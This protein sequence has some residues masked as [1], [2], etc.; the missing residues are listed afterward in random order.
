MV[1]MVV[2]AVMVDCA[3]LLL[4]LLVL[5]G[6][7]KRRV[8]FAWQV[9]S[10]KLCLQQCLPEKRVPLLF[11]LF[12]TAAAKLF[13]PPP[14]RTVTSVQQREKRKTVECTAFGKLIE[15]KEGGRLIAA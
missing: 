15:D 8:H 3:H 14:S 13:L 1:V 11:N 4:L 6:G 5:T 9:Q 12:I 2:V 10:V 7:K